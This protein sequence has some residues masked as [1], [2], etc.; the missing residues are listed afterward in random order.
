M[1]SAM[2]ANDCPIEQSNGRVATNAKTS[3]LTVIIPDDRSA[4]FRKN[5]ATRCEVGLQ[6]IFR[7]R[8]PGHR[9]SRMRVTNR[10]SGDSAP[11]IVSGT[12]TTKPTDYDVVK[13]ALISLDQMILRS[14]VQQTHA[15]Y[16]RRR[17][18][19]AGLIDPRPRSAGRIFPHQR[20]NGRGREPGKS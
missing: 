18:A 2:I 13:L 3:G 20:D 17:L 4:R 10:H 11:V 12:S 7:V 16:A 1:V 19:A 6:E 9:N 14:L 8:R 5:L 15:T